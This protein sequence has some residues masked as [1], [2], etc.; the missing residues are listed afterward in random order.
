MKA[1]MGG[2]KAPEERRR[3][4]IIRAA[5]AVAAE[6]GLASVTARAVAAE[7]R[8]SP[9][10]VFFYYATIDQLLLAL[11]DW[12]LARTVVAGEV[13]AVAAAT[14]DPAGRMMAVVRRDIERL[15]RQR[16]R[17]ELFFEYWVLGTRDPAIRRKIRRALDRYR[18]SFLPVAAA[19][20]AAEPERY[21]GATAEGLASV[22]ASFV[23]GCALQVVM[24]PTQFDVERSMTTLSAL[25]RQPA[26]A[27]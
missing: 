17:V 16:A 24:D 15:P 23:E 4:E 10:L 1:E 2:R 3:E 5:F 25:V 11:L 14:A 19:L 7:A 13:P 12:L 8:V 20:V 6:G 21:A 27:T 18:A 22:A 9:G 26:M